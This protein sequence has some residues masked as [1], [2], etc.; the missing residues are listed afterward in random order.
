M[1]GLRERIESH[2]ARVAVM[3]QGYVGL[4][5]AIEFAKAGF[6]VTGLDLD[7]EKVAAL[8][9]GESHIP[10]VPSTTVHELVSI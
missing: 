9:R 10:D 2:A 5:L 6:R 1:V 8:N 4:P 3:G 7:V